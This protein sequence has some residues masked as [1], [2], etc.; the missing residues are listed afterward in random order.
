MAVPRS[1]EARITDSVLLVD[2][3]ETRKYRLINAEMIAP[4]PPIGAS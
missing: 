3:R 1:S 2:P 4:C